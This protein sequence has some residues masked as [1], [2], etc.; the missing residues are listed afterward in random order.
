MGSTVNKATDALGTYT[1]VGFLTGNSLM[2]N[3]SNAGLL[4]LGQYKGA[5]GDYGF[6]Q[7]LQMQL[8]AAQGKTPSVA[9]IQAQQLQQQATGNAL[10]TIN[11]Q[12]GLSPSERANMAGTQTVNLQSKATQQAEL[13]RAAE[14]QKARED[15]ANMILQRQGI[16]VGMS[17][18]NAGAYKDT[19]KNRRDFISGAG[20]ALISGGG[21][22]VA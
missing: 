17:G 20:K 14:M 22:G 16:D 13:L 4:G 10:S 3:E 8:D 7:A 1:G 21:G 19:A 2:G 9:E 15:L 5:I 12:K 6:N 18:V 11:S